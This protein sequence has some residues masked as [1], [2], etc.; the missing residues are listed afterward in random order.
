MARRLGAEGFESNKKARKQVKAE[1]KKGLERAKD[2]RSERQALILACEGIETEP[3][4]FNSLFNELK[5]NHHIA[6]SSLV[7]TKHKHTDPEGVLTDL[8][9]HPGYQDYDYQW[10]V[11]DRDAE[12]TNGGGHTLQNFKN[13]ISEAK[14]KGVGIAYSNPCFEIWYLLHLDFRNTG[15]DRDELVKSLEK[16]HHYEKNKLFTL[17]S[18]KVAIRNAHQL[19]DIYHPINPAVD[20]PSTT[21]HELVELLESFKK[22]PEED[23]KDLKFKY[24]THI[25]V[26][27]GKI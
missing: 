16:K 13:A 1:A 11:I 20:N 8:L 25:T 14:S 15:I 24:N 7:I 10:I 4:Y 6:N 12:K 26:K 5:K 21:V 27:G 17:G 19:L 3:L 9:D 22:V 2:T 18:Q 23:K